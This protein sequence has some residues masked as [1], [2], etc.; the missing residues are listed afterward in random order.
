M[1]RRLYGP[2]WLGWNVSQRVLKA[3]AKLIVALVVGFLV[4][5]IILRDPWV[6]L[7]RGYSVHATN[8]GDVCR[9]RYAG[10]DDQSRRSAWEA[11]RTDGSFTLWN[12]ATDEVREYETEAEWRAAMRALNVPLPHGD[13][14][15]DVTGF[16][17]G[18]RYTIG[19]SN[20]SGYFLLDKETG[21]LR[22]W[23]L[24]DGWA[25]AVRSQ[26][27]LDP[28]VLHDPKA[29]HLQRRDLGYW[30]IMG[31]YGAAAL[32]WIVRPRPRMAVAARVGGGNR[33]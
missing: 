3:V 14:L 10:D 17:N 1:R 31:G 7:G 32:A 28:D 20:A 15:D 33:A 21:E 5:G 23:P 9:L 27:A 19:H 22:T 2:C 24:A 11:N 16:D 8:W 25:P 26:T 4:E 30:L 13:I 18:Q 12:F 6:E 29:W